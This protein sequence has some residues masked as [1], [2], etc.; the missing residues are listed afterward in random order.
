VRLLIV[1]NSV[2]A[3]GGLYAQQSPQFTWEGQVDGIVVLHVHGERVDVEYRQGAPVERQVFHFSSSLPDIRQNA[4]VEV[5]EG[6]GAVRVTQQPRI[7]NNFTADVTIEDR[8][9]GASFYSI[10]VY[11]DE[12]GTPTGRMDHVTWSGRVDG[13][14]VVGCRANRCE[15]VVR[16]GEPVGRPHTKFTRPLPNRDIRVWLDETGGRGDIKLLEQPA[17]NNNFTAKVLIRAF[18]GGGECSFIL[19]WPRDKAGRMP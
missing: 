15:P 5:R 7:E 13:E 11:W 18:G 9:D 19:S 3:L 12:R 8:Q 14:V 1:L 10:G 4:R 16:S 2:F 6:R 17:A